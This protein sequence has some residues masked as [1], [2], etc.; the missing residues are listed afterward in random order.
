MLQIMRIYAQIC[1]NRTL[2]RAKIAPFTQNEAKTF[3]SNGEA[4][5]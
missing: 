5:K 1:T 2:K 4:G 3:E